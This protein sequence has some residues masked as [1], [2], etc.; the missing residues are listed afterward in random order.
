MCRV[1]I[2]LF[3]QKLLIFFVTSA[4]ITTSVNLEFFFLSARSIPNLSWKIYVSCIKETCITL[5]PPPQHPPLSL[6]FAPLSANT[7]TTNKSIITIASIILHLPLLKFRL[8]ATNPYLYYNEK[9]FNLSMEQMLKHLRFKQN[10]DIQFLDFTYSIVFIH[11]HHV[12]FAKQ[13]A[14][15]SMKQ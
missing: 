13:N 1:N 10:R 3:I 12:F 2:C 5:L 14:I 11:P 4:D 9:N 15:P 6:F 8:D 7:T